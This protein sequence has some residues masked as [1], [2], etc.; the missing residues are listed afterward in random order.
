MLCVKANETFL[1]FIEVDGKWRSNIRRVMRGLLWQMRYGLHN[2]GLPICF[3][4]GA[5]QVVCLWGGLLG[6]TQVYRQS[7]YC[8]LHFIVR[9]VRTYQSPVSLASVCVCVCAVSV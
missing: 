4:I 8:T 7:Q 6:Y 1:L 3:R 5:K 2:R 9:S